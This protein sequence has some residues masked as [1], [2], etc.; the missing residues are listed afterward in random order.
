MSE[1]GNKISEQYI[2]YI[3]LIDFCSKVTLTFFIVSTTIII[4]EDTS[5]GCKQ[6]SLMVPN[7]GFSDILL[8]ENVNFKEIQMLLEVRIDR[9]LKKK[10]E[11]KQTI[12]IN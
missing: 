12:Y 1:G 10:K 9:L 6:S 2:F 8:C 4:V 11:K 3:H 7:G 5:G